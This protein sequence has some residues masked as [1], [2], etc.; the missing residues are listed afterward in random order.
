M[1]ANTR[2]EAKLATVRSGHRDDE[3]VNRNPLE[4]FV[5]MMFCVLILV[6]PFVLLLLAYK[7][8]IGVHPVVA[9]LLSILSVGTVLIAVWF[10]YRNETDTPFHAVK[11][12][13]LAAIHGRHRHAYEMLVDGDKDAT[14]RLMGQQEFTFDQL[15]GFR[16]YWR[17]V[18]KRGGGYG[19]VRIDNQHEVEMLD[20]D[21][22][23]VRFAFL[24]AVGKRGEEHKKLVVK[25]A[26]EWHLFNGEWSSI[27]D[28]DSTWIAR[29]PAYSQ[30]PAGIAGH[31][32][33]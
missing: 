7:A 33:A 9:I 24:D 11:Y 17:N 16:S 6:P 29:V 14:P 3:P 2:A 19:R 10:Y 26:N 22:A 8:N 25:I 30:A 5:G 31:A 15:D 21:L 4:I 20:Q 32:P 1:S 28:D 13:F 12:F 23:L 18:R 27:E